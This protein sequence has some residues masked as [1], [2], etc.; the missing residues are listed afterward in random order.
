MKERLPF[1][2]PAIPAALLAL[3]AAGLWLVSSLPASEV[4]LPAFPHIDKIAHFLY[5]LG[6]GFLFSWLLRCVVTWSPWA[7]SLVVFGVFAVVG[8]GDELHQLFTPGR[9]GADFGDW[10]ADVSGGFTGAWLFL[11]LYVLVTR[12]PHSAAPAGD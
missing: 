9:S 10:L 5:F 11:I 6:G 12:T 4:R 2:H 7:I 1:F 8:A 3:W